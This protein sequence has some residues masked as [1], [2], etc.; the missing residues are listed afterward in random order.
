MLNTVLSLVVCGITYRLYNISGVSSTPVFRFSVLISPTIFYYFHF[1]INSDGWY[2][3]RDRL[4][5]KLVRQPLYCATPTLAINLKIKAIKIS[6][7]NDSQSFEEGSV[8][9]F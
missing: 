2:Q 6:W 7:Y 4:I 5:T 8:A 3:T 9:N 1:T